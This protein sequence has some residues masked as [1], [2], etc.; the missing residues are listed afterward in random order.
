[1]DKYALLEDLSPDFQT[2]KRKGHEDSPVL[3]HSHYHQ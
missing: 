2:H 3:T 1:M